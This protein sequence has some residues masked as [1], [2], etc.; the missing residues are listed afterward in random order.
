MLFLAFFFSIFC[1]IQWFAPIFGV[2][3]DFWHFY[4]FFAVFASAGNVHVSHGVP[5]LSYA[6]WTVKYSLFDVNSLLKFQELHYIGISYL[7]AIFSYFS[8]ARS[9]EL[10]WNTCVSMEN[11]CCLILMFWFVYLEV[12]SIILESLFTSEF[13][14]WFFVWA[15]LVSSLSLTNMQCQRHFVYTAQIFPNSWNQLIHL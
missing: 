2:L 4:Q 10:P 11:A 8:L 14:G 15:P 5:Y 1:H 13:F 7:F 6:I 12:N 9:P 3:L